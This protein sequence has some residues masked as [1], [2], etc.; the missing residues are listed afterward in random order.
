MKKQ[1]GPEDR[2][3]RGWAL[4][5]SNFTQALL[6]SFISETFSVI[7]PKMPFYSLT[8]HYFTLWCI[9]LLAWLLFAL[10]SLPLEC[11]LW[12]ETRCFVH[13]C[14]LIVVVRSLS[15]VWLFATPWTEAHQASL[16]FTISQSVLKLVSI[17]LAMLSTKSSPVVPF[18][19]WL[20]SFPASKSFPTSQF[21]TS[22]GQSTGA[23]A[24]AS[25]FA[26]LNLE[27]AS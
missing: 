1:P 6:G 24:S 17:E 19:P 4:P 27:D 23:S 8:V 18:C 3:C 15:H 14:I 5:L 21:F 16:S 22:G 20:Q 12:K 2:W 10:Y 7:S 26:Q 9:S 25:V 11:R 13:C